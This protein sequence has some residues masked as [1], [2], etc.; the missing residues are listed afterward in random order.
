MQA[1]LFASDQKTHRFNVPK[2]ATKQLKIATAGDV[3]KLRVSSNLLPMFGF[4]AGQRIGI[5]KISNGV[6]ITFDDAGRQKIYERKYNSRRN[7]PCEAIL[8]L[9][10]AEVMAQFPKHV[11]RFS[12][13]MRHGNVKLRQLLDRA[14]SAR[15]ALRQLANP[16]TMFAALTSGVDIHAAQQLGFDIAGIVELRKQEARDRTD[17]TETGVLT[18]VANNNIGAIFNE[19]IYNLDWS[20]V[21]DTLD[22]PHVPV[23]HCSLSCDAF[24]TLS[25]GKYAEIGLETDRDMAFSLLDGIKRLEPSMVIVEQVPAFAKSAEYQLFRLQLQRMGYY[26]TEKIMDARDYGDITSRKRFHMIASFYPGATLPEPTPRRTTPVWDEF[27]APHLSECRDITHSKS[28]TDGEKSGRL[29]IVDKHKTY[30]NTPVKSCY[31]MANDTLCLEH[32]G[33]FLLPSEKLRKVLLSIPTDFN[34]DV[35]GETIASEIIGQSISYGMHHQ[36]LACVKNHILENVGH[37]TVSTLKTTQQTQI[38]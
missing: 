35:V 21:A 25:S 29:R 28:I 17:L 26:I 15:K 8:E 27:I 33:R 10:N 22:I 16:T 14:F 23:L 37:C 6:E 4:N 31:R 30:S 5:N 13:E 18:A 32:E 38:A 11:S 1:E 24:S 7:S 19:D 20:K 9:K 3:R 34:T 12:V 2:V 36:I